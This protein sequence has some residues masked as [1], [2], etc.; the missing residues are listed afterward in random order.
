MAT[1]KAEQGPNTLASDWAADLGTG[2]QP[3][4]SHV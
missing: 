2:T 4:H 1:I 3:F